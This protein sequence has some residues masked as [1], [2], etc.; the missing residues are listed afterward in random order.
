MEQKP[1]TGGG[2]ACV[3]YSKGIM[4]FTILLIPNPMIFG[5]TMSIS[6][7]QYL[8][9]TYTNFPQYMSS[10]LGAYNNFALIPLAVLM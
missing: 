2:G 6:C 8:D 1:S 3:I 7:L 5:M 9:Q 10:A 4:C